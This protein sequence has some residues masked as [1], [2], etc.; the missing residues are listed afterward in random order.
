M[1]KNKTGNRRQFLANCAA[2][3][4]ATAFGTNIT[5]AA[6]ADTSY[7]IAPPKIISMAIAGSSERFPVR[8]VFCLGRNYRAHAIESGDDPDT[9]PPFFFIKPRDA[10]VDASQGHPYPSMT[11]E[12]RYE[13]EMVVA[14]KVAAAI[15]VN[16]MRSITSLVTVSAST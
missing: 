10:I 14:L 2:V 5:L 11:S 7:A 13:G 6:A 1:H 8:R 15:S 12:L 3:T 4:G 9:N 16:K